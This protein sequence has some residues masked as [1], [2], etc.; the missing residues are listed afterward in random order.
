MSGSAPE[1]QSTPQRLGIPRF[2]PWTSDPI[3]YFWPVYVGRLPGPTTEKYK[4]LIII[5]NKSP[6]AL[7]P[8]RAA[9]LL[10]GEPDWQAASRQRLNGNIPA[11]S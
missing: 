9:S 5:P 8:L 4:Y 10:L 6:V 11:Q 2:K 7:K 3:T 1:Q